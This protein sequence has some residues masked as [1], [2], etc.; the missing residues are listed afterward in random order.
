MMR[1]AAPAEGVPTLSLRISHAAPQMSASTMA[2]PSNVCAS[3]PANDGSIGPGAATAAHCAEATTLAASAQQRMQRSITRDIVR[4][5][6]ARQLARALGGRDDVGQ[7]DAELFVDDDDFALCE[8]AA[9]HVDV[10]RFS[11]EAVELDYGTLRELQHVADRQPRASEL[12]G[13]LYGNIHH[14]ADVAGLSGDAWRGG[15]AVEHGGTRSGG[16]VGGSGGLRQGFGHRV[17]PAPSGRG[18]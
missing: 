2:R 6:S 17:S 9:I 12:H 13:E 1:M 4:F 15:E 11:G 7:A 8:Q 18:R 16:D 3:P 5:P 14:H 10:E